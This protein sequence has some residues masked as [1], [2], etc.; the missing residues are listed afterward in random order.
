[1]IRIFLPISRCDEIKHVRG[2]EIA[3]LDNQHPLRDGSERVRSYGR[4]LYSGEQ[5]VKQW[6]RVEVE[7][8]GQSHSSRHL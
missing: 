3:D 5:S 7:A 4:S 1:M 6:A 8:R 2:A